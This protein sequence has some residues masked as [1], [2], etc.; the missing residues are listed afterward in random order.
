MTIEKA[1]ELV[2]ELREMG[3]TYQ[4]ASLKAI[5]LFTHF[6]DYFKME[7]NPQKM[8]NFAAMCGYLVAK[9]ITIL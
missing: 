1:A 6:I 2:S 9:N 3:K 7:G 8:E 4:P 5:D